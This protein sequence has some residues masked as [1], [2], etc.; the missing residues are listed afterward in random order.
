MSIN[1]PY[2]SGHGNISEIIQKLRKQFPA[3]IT[4]DTIKKFRIAPNNES[5]LINA[6]QFIGVID[7]E[8]KKN[9]EKAKVFSQ[10]DDEKFHEEFSEIIKSAYY[11]LF[12]LHGD[13]AWT[14]EDADLISFFRQTDNTS[15]TTGKRQANAFKTFSSLCGKIE[16]PIIKKNNAK[17][18]NNK[19][20]KLSA[21]SP[22]TKK[23]SKQIEPKSPFD[24]L[25]MS[26]K[27]DVNLP[28]D[29]TKETYDNIF[30]SIREHLING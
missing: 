25:G 18:N 22:D 14:L 20:T 3:T 23:T 28:S 26:I 27:I 12:D 19:P 4:S 5:Y 24:Q 7:A 17:T 9:S 16:I 15:D 6:L 29:A 30:K 10:H 11:Q 2:I 1:H 13:N 8:G 21:K